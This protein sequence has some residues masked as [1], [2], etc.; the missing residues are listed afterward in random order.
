MWPP[1]SRAEAVRALIAT[2]EDERGKERH[3]PFE[4]TTFCPS[5]PRVY[6]P[7]AQPPHCIHR[8]ATPV[9][10]KTLVCMGTIWCHNLYFFTPS[11]PQ[12]FLCPMSA[13]LPM[14]R[15]WPLSWSG[16]PSLLDALATFIVPFITE[17][18]QINWR[19]IRKVVEQKW[20]QRRSQNSW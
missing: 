20:K 12:T 1:Y 15:P 19:Q 5:Q 10:T 11:A 3:E 13:N 6:R 18:T 4:D 17:A 16:T 2:I 14:S 8:S 7:A 9:Y